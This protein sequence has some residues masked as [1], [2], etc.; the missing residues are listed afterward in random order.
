MLRFFRIERPTIATLRPTW[1]ATSIACCIRWTF[2]A[3]E[4]TRI[5]A[6]AQRDQRPE[7]L[8]DEPLGAGHPGPLGVGRVAEQQV[9][10]LVAEL[11]EPADV[12]L[13]P[14]DGRVVELPVAGV[15]DAAGGRLEH[16]RDAVR[17][18]VRHAHEVERER[19]DLDLLVRSSASCSSVDA[20]RP[21]SSSFDLIRPSVSFVAITLSQST[22]RSRYGSPPTWSSWPCVSTTAL[23]RFA[24]EVADVGQDEVDAE[25]LVAREREAGVDDD[26]LVAVL[27]DGHV[28]A[29]LAEAAERDDPQAHARECMRA[30]NG[31]AA[32]PRRARAG[33][34]GRGS[35]APAR[36]RPRS[37]RRAAAGGRRPRGRAGS[38][39]P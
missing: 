30:R 38:A 1:T 21:C 8:A 12:G 25:V 4:T 9:D 23:T 26:D 6:A 19:A 36:A 15:E 27:V 20:E 34:A 39:P 16:D 13:E 31:R 3:N 29:D 17:D 14:V 28:L 35:R 33:R 5:A 7:R 37:P 2:E 10:A 22:S 11:G 32:R 18:R 24:L